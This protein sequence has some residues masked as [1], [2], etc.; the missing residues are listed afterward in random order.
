MGL[1]SWGLHNEQSPDPGEGA[2]PLGFRVY[3]NKHPCHHYHLHHHHT[4]SHSQLIRVLLIM[5]DSFVLCGKVNG[6]VVRLDVRVLT[7]CGELTF[8][9]WLVRLVTIQ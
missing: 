5:R 9:G 6:C 4:T 1:T 8:V 3:C 2:C 7:I